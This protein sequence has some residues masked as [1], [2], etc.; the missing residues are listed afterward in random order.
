MLKKTLIALAAVAG[1]AAILPAQAH[2]RDDNR[3]SLRIFAGPPVQLV[4]TDWRR[5]RYEYYR[6]DHRPYYYR[7]YRDYRHYRHHDRDDWRDRD[8][9][10]HHDRH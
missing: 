2:D 5:D 1:F 10:R 8:G 4:H 3:L 9:W 7:E 6:H